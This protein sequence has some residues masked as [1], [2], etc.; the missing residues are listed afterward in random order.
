MDIAHHTLIGGVGFMMIT[1]SNQELSGIAAG[2]A[3]L[4]GS[5]LPDLDVFL[6]AFGK[7]LYLKNHQGFTHS[8]LLSPL[9]A[10]LVALSLTSLLRLEWNW[11]I[12]LASILGLWLHSFLDVVNTF[13]ISLFWPL[14]QKRFSYDAVF[15]IDAF[16]WIMTIILYIFIFSFNIGSALYIYTSAFT[17]YILF[18]LALHKKIM[19]EL[20]CTYAIPGS[21]NP[22]NYYILEKKDGL[23][24]TYLYNAVSRKT[25]NERSY[26]YPMT[27]FIK[28]AET[29]MLFKDMRS[30]TRF[31]H[32]TDIKEENGEITIVAKDLAVRNFGGNF[33]R[34]TLKFNR[35]GKLARETSHI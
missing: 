10:L 16:A 7:R 18:K 25:R 21:F 17:L 1:G 30:I 19:N 22:F 20:K 32:I 23:I 8:L 12:F 33:G 9:L 4:A 34:T 5:V 2:S 28:M 11:F 31:F 6:M 14:S 13:G 35:N 15:F 24:K 29:S 3:F 27:R 26:D